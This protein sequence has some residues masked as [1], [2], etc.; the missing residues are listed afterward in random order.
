MSDNGRGKS[1]LKFI[2]LLI[3]CTIFDVVKGFVF[4]I[5]LCM[6]SCTYILHIPVYAYNLKLTFGQ[7]YIN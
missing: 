2:Y 5:F 4:F 1:C 3:Y 6:N 7:K